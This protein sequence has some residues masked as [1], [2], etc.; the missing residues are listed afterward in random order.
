[1]TM[2]STKTSDI[3][4]ANSLLRGEI[5]AVETYEQAIKKLNEGEHKSIA[6]ELTRIRNEH[7]QASGALRQFVTKNGGDPSEGA[8]LW[9]VFA[10]SVACAA[11]MF[12][13]ETVIDALKQ[14]EQHGLAEYEKAAENPD[15]SESCRAIIRNQL[16]LEHE[17]LLDLERMTNQL[18]HEAAKKK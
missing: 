8:G 18:E 13:P 9:G 16:P 2:D 15:I 11:K 4:V 12:G 5:S 17:H 14:G 7:S 6:D 10:N 3:E 1:M